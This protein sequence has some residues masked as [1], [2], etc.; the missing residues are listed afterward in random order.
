MTPQETLEAGAITVPILQ[1]K[2]S[3]VGGLSHR[4]CQQR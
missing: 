1:M 4:P 2:K 3:E